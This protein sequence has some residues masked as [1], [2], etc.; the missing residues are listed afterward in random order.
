MEALMAKLKRL[1]QDLEKLRQQVYEAIRDMKGDDRLSSSEIQ[2]LMSDFNQAEAL[3]S[4]IMKKMD[5]SRKAVTVK[6]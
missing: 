5:K 1:K 6:P 3:V 4:R 2:D